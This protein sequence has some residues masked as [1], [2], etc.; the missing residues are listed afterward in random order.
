M[1]L[2]ERKV[3]VITGASSGIG[4]ATAL[5]FAR[6]GASV[7][8]AAR[9]E[10]ALRRVAYDISAL[11]SQCEVVPTDVSRWDQMCRLATQSISRFGVIDIWVNN[12][13][14]ATFGALE[15]TP[16][17]ALER[18]IQVNLLG[19]M[20]G[21]KAALEYMK[22][23]G[24]GS[25]I[26]VG[27]IL[28]LRAVPFEASYCAS[29]YGVKGFTDSLRLELRKTGIDVTLI[30]PYSINTPIF[31]NAL[32]RLGA[33]PRPI[34]PVY[35]PDMVARA[36]VAA[37]RRPRREVLVGFMA[38]VVAA[39]ER[40]SPTLLERYILV[41]DRMYTQMKSGAPDNGVDNLFTSLSGDDKSWRKPHSTRSFD[42][43]HLNLRDRYRAI[44]SRTV[45]AVRSVASRIVKRR[46]RPL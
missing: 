20:Y 19:E 25:I 14:V 24:H 5:E 17:E 1:S 36:I 8:L 42:V 15:D 4:R 43:S 46:N 18:L 37:A 41:A 23:R 39:A 35:E 28:S 29:K 22:P 9:S 32:S 34:P 6:C 7:V 30:V 13:A 12:A 10:S 33:M 45:G 2:L 11:G 44:G 26:N 31:S 21:C 27:S 3:V 40:I 16:P 38:H